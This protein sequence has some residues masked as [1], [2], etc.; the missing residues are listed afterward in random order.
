MSGLKL[1]ER[2]LKRC[3]RKIRDSIRDLVENSG[4]SGVVLGLSGGIDSAVVLMLARD[5]VD[6]KVLLMP[7]E[8]LS[9]SADSMALVERLGVNYSVVKI[10]PV[11][12]ALEASYPWGGGAKD[13]VSWGNV[14][15]RVRMMLNYLTANMENRI[16]L[17]TGNKTELLMGYFTK[18]GDGGVDL[19]PIGDLYKTQVKQVASSI[20][21]PEKIIK[22]TPS[23]ELWSGQTDEGEMGCSYDDL[24]K[25][26]YYMIDMKLPLREVS[27]KSKL[28]LTLVESIRRRVARNK[29]KRSMPKVVRIF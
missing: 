21:V 8:G 24:D 16:V 28:P 11:L 14:K 5:I 22:K 19:L 26:L 18:Y 29:H 12:E 15:P 23:A 2:E 9:D 17:G 4:A 27:R 6:V 20:G 3:V 13:K 10:N 1:S 7:E 25:V